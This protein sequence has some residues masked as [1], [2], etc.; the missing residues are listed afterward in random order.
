MGIQIK[1]FPVLSKKYCQKENFKLGFN[2]QD[3]PFKYVKSR[4]NDVF[5]ALLGRILKHY[6]LGIVS[7][8]HRFILETMHCF[9]AY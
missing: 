3:W 1:D 6:Y 8:E 2:Q 4:F 5:S 9:I 7:N